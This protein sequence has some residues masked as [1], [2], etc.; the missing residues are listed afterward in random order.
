MSKQLKI[1]DWVE[2]RSKEEILQ[3]LDSRGW[4]DGMPFMPEML[5]FCGKRFQVYKSAHKTCDYSSAKIR[6]RRVEDTVHLRTQCDGSAH[7][8]CQAGCLLYWK[9]AWLKPVVAGAT[10][11][12]VRLPSTTEVP[13]NCT[14]SDL[15]SNTH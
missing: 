15:F 8:G 5:Q 9:E 10:N 14:E 2:V 3:T 7:D 4:L 1:G 12:L 6:S 11:E 13:S